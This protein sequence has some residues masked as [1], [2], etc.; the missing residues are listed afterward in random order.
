MH[1][2][3]LFSLDC[4]TTTP[5]HCTHYTAPPL[6]QCTSLHCNPTIPQN[7]SSLHPLHC[8]PNNPLYFAALYSQHCTPTTL[9]HCTPLIT[10]LYSINFN[11]ITPLHFIA[12]ALL[13]YNLLCL[14]T[15]FTIIACHCTLLHGV[16]I[17]FVLYFTALHQEFISHTVHCCFNSSK[18]C[19]FFTARCSALHCISL[20]PQSTAPHSTAPHCTVQCTILHLIIMY[21]TSLHS[22]PREG[23]HMHLHCDHDDSQ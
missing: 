4:T 16:V 9:L 13:H 10:A 17:Y 7:F 22:R 8:T 6:L 20:A 2:I 3:A 15:N 12:P 11:A 21:I 1:F 5:L 19:L 14:T 18:T 23:A